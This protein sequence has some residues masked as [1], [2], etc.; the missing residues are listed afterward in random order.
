MS[1]NVDTDKLQQPA[2]DDNRPHDA[3]LHGRDFGAL[4]VVA[5]ALP[6]YPCEQSSDCRMADAASARAA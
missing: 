4:T 5:A 2:G 1:L 6:R 3:W